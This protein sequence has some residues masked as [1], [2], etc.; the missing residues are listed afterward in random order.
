MSNAQTRSRVLQVFR[1]FQSML[2]KWVSVS[3]A[4][5]QHRDYAVSL[6][7]LSD[8]SAW[9]TWTMQQKHSLALTWRGTAKSLLH[10]K[11]VLVGKGCMM[12]LAPRRAPDCGPPA[13]HSKHCHLCS[14]TAIG[15]ETETLWCFFCVV[16]WEG[17]LQENH[18]TVDLRNMQDSEYIYMALEEHSRCWETVLVQQPLKDIIY[19]G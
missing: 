3:M 1:H 9:L 18:K 15:Q 5:K 16:R 14:S 19:M 10:P 8:S 2:G 7:Q 12:L 6:W 13:A 17:F 11:A 4:S